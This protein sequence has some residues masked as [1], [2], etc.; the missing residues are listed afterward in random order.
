MEPTPRLTIAPARPPDA[1]DLARLMRGLNAHEGDPVGH[2]T[3]AAMLRDVCAE[4]RAVD[5]LIARLGG[6]AVGMALFHP[7]YEAPYAARGSFVTDLFVAPEA[8]RRGVGRALLAEAARTTAAR[9]GTYLWLTAL[10]RNAGARAFYR[11]VCDVEDDDIVVF[12]LTR[13]RFADLAR[14]G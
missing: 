2:A 7:A 3:E 8:R 10:G 1:A 12:A 14:E 4:G 9:G 6:A 11:A 13:E 5:G